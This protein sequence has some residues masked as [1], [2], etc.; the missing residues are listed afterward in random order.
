MTLLRGHKL[1]LFV[2]KLEPIPLVYLLRSPLEQE[3][4]P[5]CQVCQAEF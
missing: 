1:E 5:A 2:S 4:V 3:N